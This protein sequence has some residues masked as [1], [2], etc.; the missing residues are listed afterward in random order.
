M[1]RQTR[2]E[3]FKGLSSRLDKRDD[4]VILKI[5]NTEMTRGEMV[6]IFGCDLGRSGKAL[7]RAFAKMRVKNVTELATRMTVGDMFDLG[8]RLGELAALAFGFALIKEGAD[9][10]TWS[11]G[12]KLSTTYNRRKSKKLTKAFHRPRRDNVYKFRKAR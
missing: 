3:R 11:N 8:L 4:D 10:V 1:N 7:T 5:G 2:I 9:A 12:E 6:Q